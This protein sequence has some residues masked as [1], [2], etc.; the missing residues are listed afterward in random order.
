[1]PIYLS[2]LDAGTPPFLTITFL[3]SSLSQFYTS[4]RILTFVLCDLAFGTSPAE[5]TIDGILTKAKYAAT[6]DVQICG[7]TFPAVSNWLTFLPSARA[8][9]EVPWFFTLTGTLVWFAGVLALI[10]LLFRAVWL[11]LWLMFRVLHFLLESLGGFGL[12]AV[13]VLGGWLGMKEVP[14]VVVVETGE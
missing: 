1:M 2:D 3:K 13:G 4:G 6:F 7:S 9:V 5:D 14:V 12:W 10:Y 11:L 8:C